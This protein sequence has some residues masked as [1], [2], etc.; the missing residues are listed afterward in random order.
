MAADLMLKKGG[1]V[2]GGMAQ[3]QL[4]AD[5]AS[6]GFYGIP[7]NIEQSPDLIGTEALLD[8]QGYAYFY[9]RQGHDHIMTVGHARSEV[10][11]VRRY[12]VQRRQA[13]SRDFC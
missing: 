6:A 4:A 10:G 12:D 11:Q 9:G 3:A 1:P 7:R 13:F 5:I 8:H 2:G